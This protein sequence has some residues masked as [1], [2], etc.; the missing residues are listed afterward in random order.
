MSLLLEIKKIDNLQTRQS[1]SPYVCLLKSGFPE[2][3]IKDQIKKHILGLESLLDSK[4]KDEELM[5]VLESLID[6]KAY[7]S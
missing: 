4:P 6:L 5:G 3:Q 1:L 2:W 7:V